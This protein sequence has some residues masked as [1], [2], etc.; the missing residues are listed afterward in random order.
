MFL[1]RCTERILIRTVSMSWQKNPWAIFQLFALSQLARKSLSSPECFNRKRKRLMGQRRWQEEFQ[2][3]FACIAATKFLWSIWRI[4]LEN[5]LT[6]WKLC[7]IKVN[8]FPHSY[9]HFIG[10]YQCSDPAC[11]NKSRQ[12][13]IN[14]KCVINDCNG[15]MKPEYSEKKVNDTFRFLQTLF[16]V[17]T[18][19]SELK[20]DITE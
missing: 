4:W 3:W 6:R 9:N 17:E 15:R 14:N 12:L 16:D 10:V 7:I 20:I 19:K 2:D 18:Y 13:C 8:R 11:N 1:A 5:S